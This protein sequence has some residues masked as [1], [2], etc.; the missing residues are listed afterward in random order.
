MHRSISYPFSR[1]S[2]RNCPV[3]RLGGGELRVLPEVVVRVGVDESK[4]LRL[5]CSQCGYT[6]LFDA[7]LAKSTP[8]R[9]TSTIEN[10]PDLET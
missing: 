4:L 10:F 2:T 9:D 6:M 8:Y 5:A 7:E 3:C 1:I